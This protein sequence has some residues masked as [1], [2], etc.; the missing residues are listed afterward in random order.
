MDRVKGSE[1]ETG[2][3]L[4]FEFH[5]VLLFTTVSCFDSAQHDVA[6]TALNFA[7]TEVILSEV[8]VLLT[9]QK[10]FNQLLSLS[11]SFCQIIIH[12]NFIK[13]KSISELMF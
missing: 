2:F 7:N 1:K 8:E 10:G 11:N 4:F 3:M 13:R 9:L 5:S 12:N 6:S